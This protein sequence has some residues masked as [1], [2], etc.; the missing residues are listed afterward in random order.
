MLSTWAL[1]VCSLSPACFSQYSKPS[2]IGWFAPCIAW[3]RCSYVSAW[4]ASVMQPL[5]CRSDVLLPPVS[6]GCQDE[7]AILEKRNTWAR[8]QVF[9]LKTASYNQ[10]QTPSQSVEKV[11]FKA[12]QERRG[13]F[14]LIGHTRPF[15]IEGCH[16]ECCVKRN[17]SKRE[18]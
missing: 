10:H 18:W 13:P 15:N 17:A 12:H 14:L 8:V 6:S 3:T 4:S 11:S 9:L 1:I 7:F 5:S 2:R 16:L